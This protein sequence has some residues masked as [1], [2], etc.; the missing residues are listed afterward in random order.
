M[1]IQIL[2]LPQR[3]FGD[4]VE[5]PFALILDEC[6]EDML[7]EAFGAKDAAVSIGAVGALVFAD[8]VEVV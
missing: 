8:R 5:T 2:P 1:R 4:A 6:P 3:V 7:T